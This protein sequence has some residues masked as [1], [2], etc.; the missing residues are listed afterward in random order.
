MS[1][2]KVICTL[3]AALFVLVMTTVGSLAHAAPS[4]SIA[5]Q[6]RA[7]AFVKV[8]ETYQFVTAAGLPY[9]GKV[10][11]VSSDGWVRI[12]RKGKSHS[13]WLNTAQVLLVDTAG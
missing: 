4:Q 10:L 8:G 3:I 2:T 7:L 12:V 6:G 9:E 1:R 11:E 5:P 13:A